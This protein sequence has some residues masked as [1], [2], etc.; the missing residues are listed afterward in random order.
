[1]KHDIKLNEEEG[2]EA[3]TRPEESEP[4]LPVLRGRME[5]TLMRDNDEPKKVSVGDYL[6]LAAILETEDVSSEDVWK[7]VVV[8][9]EDPSGEKERG[10]DSN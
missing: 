2:G 3:S 1:M 9:W 6:K 7:E 8:R 10:G 4:F 5:T